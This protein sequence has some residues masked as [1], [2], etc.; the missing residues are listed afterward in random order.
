HTAVEGD[1]AGIAA[2]YLD[3]DDA[4]VGLGGS[5]HA[6]DGFGGNADRGIEAETKIGAAEIVINGLG[7]AHDLDSLL[8]E[9]LGDRLRIVAAES[10]QRV[11]LVFC[12]GFDALR[13]S[14]LALGGVG[15]RCAQNGSAAQQNV[16]NG[17]QIELRRLIFQDAAPALDESDELVSIVKDTFSYHG[18]DYGIESGAITTTSK[19]SDSHISLSSGL[20]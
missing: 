5:M 1:P 3:H 10:N 2:H 7:H 11:Q 19:N 6:I 9:L 15:A 16:G 18:S 13:D 14:T 4:I 20:S 17:I 8:K 12:Q